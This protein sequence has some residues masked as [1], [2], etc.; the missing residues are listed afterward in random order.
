MLQRFQEFG[1]F[2]SVAFV[3]FSLSLDLAS[4]EW[5]G[6][7]LHHF[8]T[9]RPG[10][11]P[12][13]IPVSISLHCLARKQGKSVFD[14]TKQNSVKAWYSKAMNQ[15]YTV[16]LNPLGVHLFISKIHSIQ[17]IS[18]SRCE[19]RVEYSYFLQIRV[20]NIPPILGPC[21]HGGKV[22]LLGRLPPSIVFPGFVYMPGRVTLLEGLTFHHVKGRGRV[23]LLRGLIFRLSDYCCSRAIYKHGLSW[24]CL[25][26]ILG[27]T[28][29]IQRR[30]EG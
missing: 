23:T 19:Y 3:F 11:L 1:N 30:G 20:W 10:K 17:E 22:T 25:L 5:P 15:D 24:L 29:H 6:P 12:F 14:H 4:I 2:V 9:T 26:V 21:L 16:R 18:L 8:E 13:T 28:F 27:T 7:T